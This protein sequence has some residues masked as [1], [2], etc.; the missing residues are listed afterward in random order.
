MSVYSAV[1][2]HVFSQTP[3]I[4]CRQTELHAAA[5]PYTVT[6]CPSIA[7][8]PVLLRVSKELTN[9]VR[10]SIASCHASFLF[11]C[12]DGLLDAFGICCLLCV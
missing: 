12:T 6:A 7:I 2:R 5:C 3:S 8:G 11:N 4:T 10:D 1:L 9:V